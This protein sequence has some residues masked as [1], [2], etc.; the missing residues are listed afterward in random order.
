MK[1]SNVEWTKATV[2]KIT[3]KMHQVVQRNQDIIPYTTDAEGHYVDVYQ[4]DPFWWTN[5]FWGGLLWQL[6][7]L[8]GDNIYKDSAIGVEKK[9]DQ[10][11]SV[12]DHLD[13]DN[14]FKWSLTSVAH[15]RT[16]QDLDAKNR[17]LLAAEN[18]A[19]RFNLNGR[20]IR[21]WNDDGGENRS[22]SAVID[23]LMNLPLLY[24][25]S[26]EEQDPRFY[27]IAVAHAKTAQEYIVRPD[28]SVKHIINFDPR[29]GEY[30]NSV[31]GQGYEHG[32]SWTRGQAWGIYGFTLSYQYTHDESFLDTA[33]QIAQYFI[34][35]TPDDALI[36]IDFR[37]PASPWWE[38][39]SAA[40]IAASGLIELAKNVDDADATVY[41][42]AAMSLLRALDEKSS[43]WN[44]ETDNILTKC[45]AQYFED[46]HEYPI[47]YGD[48]FFIEAVLKLSN[49]AMDLW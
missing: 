30:I 5:G 7:N 20:F 37:M 16:S 28:G 39:S 22:G 12:A 26:E 6:Y 29:T 40:A 8:T 23:C 9:L 43:D 3:Q 31:G 49:Q 11:L 47:I 19:G 44:C 33:K 1:Q 41:L 45:S 13:H 14:G 10:N 25:A 38:D 2:Y 4:K 36:P 15:Y 21:A 32:S 46:N 24:W 35:N 42:K 27:Q 34:T 17:A 18:L 48:Y